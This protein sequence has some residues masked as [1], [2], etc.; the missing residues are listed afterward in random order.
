MAH[1][2]HVHGPDCDHDH[3]DHEIE[4]VELEDENGEKE[5]YAILDELD[6][7]GRHFCI[8]APLAEVQAFTEGD[9]SKEEPNL[10]IEIFEVKDDDF[11]ILE[12]EEMAKRLLA[13]LDELSDQ[14]EEEGN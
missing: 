13:H 14:L 7:E 10:S 6:F 3:D 2:E 8:M 5:E 9:E 1:D 11:T 4:V 12:D